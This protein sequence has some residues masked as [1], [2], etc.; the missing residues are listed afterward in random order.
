MPRSRE[1]DDRNAGRRARTELT[2]DLRLRHGIQALEMHRRLGAVSPSGRASSDGDAEEELGSSLG[3]IGRGMITL[4]G[5]IVLLSAQLAL[6][7]AL[8]PR[9]VAIT[10]RLSW[11][12][13]IYPMVWG[14]RGGRGGGGGER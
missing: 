13:C 1:C 10:R 8:Q 12:V 4:G 2:F 7:K 9:P 3:K 11:V 14:E 6:S 5:D